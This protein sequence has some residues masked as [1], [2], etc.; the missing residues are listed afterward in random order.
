[1]HMEFHMYQQ[2]ILKHTVEIL[3]K[4]LRTLRNI[5]NSRSY[6]M[7]LLTQSLKQAE[8][9]P[10]YKL[11]LMELGLLE[12]LLR[13]G[14]LKRKLRSIGVTI[15][16]IK[17]LLLSQFSDVQFGRHGIKRQTFLLQEKLT[18]QKLSLTSSNLKILRKQCV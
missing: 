5:L 7:V 14:Y 16:L 8:F 3:P 11:A 4:N 13:L 1:M 6:C 10:A 12:R 17:S 15:L 18:L 9:K 2:L